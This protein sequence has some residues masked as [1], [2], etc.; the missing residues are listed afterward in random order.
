MDRRFSDYLSERF[1]RIFVGV[2]AGPFLIYRRGRFRLWL[3][4]R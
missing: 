2:D 4:D 1:A 3:S